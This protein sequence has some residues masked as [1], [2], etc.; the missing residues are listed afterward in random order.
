MDD[1]KMTEYSPEKRPNVINGHGLKGDISMA[2]V[3]D[4]QTPVTTPGNP[5]QSSIESIASNAASPAYNNSS[6]YHVH[7]QDDEMKP[8]P[9]KRAR[10]QVD[11]EH[12]SK[13]NV[14][15]EQFI[16]RH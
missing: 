16:V 2:D 10:M 3:G 13:T 14:S 12:P 8:P 9:T 11:V 15:L 7:D 4:V 1:V 5:P 6:D